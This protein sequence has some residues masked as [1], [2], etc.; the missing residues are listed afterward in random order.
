MHQITTSQALRILRYFVNYTSVKL[1]KKSAKDFKRL[2]KEDAASPR[3]HEEMFTVTDHCGDAGGPRGDAPSHPA[4]SHPARGLPSEI[5]EKD[6]YRRGWR[7]EWDPG[8]AGGSA[9][10][11]VPQITQNRNFHSSQRT[12][13]WVRPREN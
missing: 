6:T 3:G 7:I 11:A 13:F 1:G 10:R 9:Q 2:S 12:R 5:T 4:P 8:T